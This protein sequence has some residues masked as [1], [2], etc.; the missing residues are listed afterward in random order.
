VQPDSDALG[1]VY[2]LAPIYARPSRSSNYLYFWRRPTCVVQRPLKLPVTL[3]M[4]IIQEA[5]EIKDIN[6]DS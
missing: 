1:A 5:L 4:Q 2:Q 3:R 6:I